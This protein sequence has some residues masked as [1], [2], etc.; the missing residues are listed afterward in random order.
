MKCGEF[1]VFGPGNL[2]EQ[3]AVLIYYLLIFG[4][5]LESLARGK[6]FHIHHG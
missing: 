2:G 1:R 6:K 3:L 4:E 5:N